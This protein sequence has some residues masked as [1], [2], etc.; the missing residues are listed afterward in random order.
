MAQYLSL[1]PSCLCST[2]CLPTLCSPLICWLHSTW[3]SREA[4]Q[5]VTKP[6]GSTKQTASKAALSIL[7]FCWL[8]E[9]SGHGCWPRW[10]QPSSMCLGSMPWRRSRAIPW[11]GARWGAP[12]TLGKLVLHT[13]PPTVETD[14][15]ALRWLYHVS[16]T[17]LQ[18]WPASHPLTARG[19]VGPCGSMY[20]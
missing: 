3:L 5:Y 9:G 7:H 10:L 8:H 1:N 11:D 19:L 18:P 2:L 17:D 13:F 15:I 20:H 14:V 12:A 6:R 16:W 4:P